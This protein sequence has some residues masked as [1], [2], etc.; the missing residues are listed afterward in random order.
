MLFHPVWPVTV[1]TGKARAQ[2]PALFRRY[3][4]FIHS[5][6]DVGCSMFIGYFSDQTGRGAASGWAD[7]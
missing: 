3:T 5:T 4:E 7:I 6:F 1:P 2:W